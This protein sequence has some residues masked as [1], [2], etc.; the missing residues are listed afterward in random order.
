MAVST[1]PWRSCERTR[2]GSSLSTHWPSSV[3]TCFTLTARGGA[4]C[5]RQACCTAYVLHALMLHGLCCSP[6][7][8]S[9]VKF[10]NR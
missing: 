10:G 8:V 5:I 4:L 7:G 6:L 2:A 1:S 3:R 9:P